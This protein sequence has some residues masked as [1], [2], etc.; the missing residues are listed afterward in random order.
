MAIRLLFTVQ[1]RPCWLF[2]GQF[3]ENIT[4]DVN[5]VSV[6]SDTDDISSL[7]APITREEVLNDINRVKRGKTSSIDR[8]PAE[9]LKT[10]LELLYYS[11]VLHIVLI[12]TSFL[13][14]GV[15]C[16]IACQK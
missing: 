4:E 7:H 3:L 2:D 5:N 8:I 12:I 9:A 6:N 10:I 16:N 1:Y 11:T 15:M 13:K 14:S